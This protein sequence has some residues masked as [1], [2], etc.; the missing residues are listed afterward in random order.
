M[1]EKSNKEKKL[2]K[3]TRNGKTFYQKREVNVGKKHQS[4]VSNYLK[5]V[6]S[7]CSGKQKDFFEYQ[8]K[9]GK[10]VSVEK[11]PTTIKPG[12]PQLK[13]CY[14]NSF[15]VV[16]L[17]KGVK[18]CEGLVSFSGGIV[19]EHAWN[20]KDGLYFDVTSEGP[21]E[22]KGF[23]EYF[24]IVELTK[25]D[26]KKIGTKRDYESYIAKVFKKENNL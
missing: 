21:L 24:S 15:D 26:L 25:E 7:I 8:L 16:M 6:S 17:N 12:Q 2:V 3:V 18:Y 9:K 14:Q 20:E 23:D 19:I 22:G 13:Q 10:V 11:T 5:Q 4:V 1:E